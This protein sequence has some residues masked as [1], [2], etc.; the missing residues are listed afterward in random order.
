MWLL[1]AGCALLL[2][3]PVVRTAP[4]AVEDTLPLVDRAQR[5]LVDLIKIDS[6]NPQ[7]SETKI[8][9]YLRQVANSNGIPCELLG[10]NPKRLNFVAR[11]KG[12]GKSKPLLLMAHSDTIPAGDRTAWTT[13]PF[14]A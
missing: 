9:E 12:N 14:G 4:G 3:S 5:Y 13:D 2:F 7:G 11:L 6:S 8:A 10:D 1:R